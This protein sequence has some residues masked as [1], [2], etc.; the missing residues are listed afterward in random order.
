MKTLD[1]KTL[2]DELKMLIIVQNKTHQYPKPTKDTYSPYWYM[3][4]IL[5]I[6][7]QAGQLSLAIPPWMTTVVMVAAIDN[8]EMSSTV[9]Q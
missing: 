6:S 3:C 8:K 7:D 1:E 9:Y 2:K 5:V 4:A